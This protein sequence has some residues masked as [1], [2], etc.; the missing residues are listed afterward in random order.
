MVAGHFDADSSACVLTLAKIVDNIVHRPDDARTRQIRCANA[1]FQQKVI[2][3]LRIPQTVV[4]D[5]KRVSMWFE[6]GSQGVVRI[7]LQCGSVLVRLS[8]PTGVF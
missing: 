5:V 3:S 4:L 6:F 7:S 2:T 1:T 8:I